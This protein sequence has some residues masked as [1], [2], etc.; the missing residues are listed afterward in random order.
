MTAR[1]VHV[2]T[3]LRF[4]RTCTSWEGRFPARSIPRESTN[5]KTLI[6]TGLMLSASAL[7]ADQ[8]I[9]PDQPAKRIAV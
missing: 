1:C 4:V 8:G 5:L 2:R 6:L 9:E 7:V 3:N